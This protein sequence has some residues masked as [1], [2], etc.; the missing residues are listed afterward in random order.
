MGIAGLLPQLRSITRKTHISSYRGQTGA[1]SLQFAAHHHCTRFLTCADPPQAATPPQ[2]T[3]P[4]RPTFLAYAPLLPQWLLM[5]TVSCTA[6][7]TRAHA[8]WLKASLLTVTCSTA[9]PVLAC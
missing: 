2:T 3:M 7:R 9:W 8:S 1:A 6:V 5:H 4:L